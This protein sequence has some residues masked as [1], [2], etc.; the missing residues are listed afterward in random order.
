MNIFVLYSWNANLQ[1]WC[2]NVGLHMNGMENLVNHN[3][4]RIDLKQFVWKQG[5]CWILHK[6]AGFRRNYKVPIHIDVDA[7]TMK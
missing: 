4:I 5:E 2:Q 7:E 6:N 3:R 1:I